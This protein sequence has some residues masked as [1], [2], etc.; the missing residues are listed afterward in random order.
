MT[1][2]RDTSIRYLTVPEVIAIHQ[3]AM[4]AMG[5][6]AAPLRSED[7]LFSAVMRAQAAA[8]Y[9]GADFAMQASVLAIG[10]SQNQPF[11]DGNKRTALVS[12]LQFATINGFAY[13][14]D[15]FDIADQL[16]AVAER[17]GSLGEATEA[18]AA[19]LRERIVAR[20]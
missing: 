3:Q 8:H 14:G 6:A 7:L 16:I 9:G 4:R 12:L 15:R 11:L 17:E 20:T 2:D 13:V 19:W 5:W 10:I 18:F 1:P